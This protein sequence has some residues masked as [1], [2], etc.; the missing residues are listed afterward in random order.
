MP[1]NNQVAASSFYQKHQFWLLLFAAIIIRFLPFV[2]IPFNWLESYFHEIS[3]GLA[4]LA[5]GGKI[6]NIQLFPNGAGLC[7]TQGGSRLLTSFMGYFGAVLWGALIYLAVSRHRKVAQAVSIFIVLLLATS[8]IFWVRDLLTLFI[9]GVLLTMFVYT[10][11]STKL[12]YIQ[13]FMQLSGLLVILNALFSPFYLLDGRHIGDGATLANLTFV[14]E[15]VWIMI[16]GTF[17]LYA[18]YFLGL[19]N[20]NKI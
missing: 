15:F 3:H 18:L 20:K 13:K 8:I 1:Q 14:P 9:T 16:W 6:V 4:A 5:S 7:T 11:K 2:S 17:A 12:N 19:R 10:A